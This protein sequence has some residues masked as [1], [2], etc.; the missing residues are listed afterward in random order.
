VLY[1]DL[2]KLPAADLVGQLC[3]V[4]LKD[5]GLLLKRLAQGEAE[6]MF[7]LISA[8]GTPVRNADIV[9]AAKVTAVIQR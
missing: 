9:W 2:R 5:G 7:D 8:V 6:G 4:A 3:V 1:D